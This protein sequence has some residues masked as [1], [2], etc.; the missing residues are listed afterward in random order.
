[1]ETKK[2]SP[3]VEEFVEFFKKQIERAYD[4]EQSIHQL[5]KEGR[6]FL[7]ERCP[8]KDEVC[9]R[10]R[11]LAYSLDQLN[12]GVINSTALNCMD[13]LLKEAEKLV[14]MLRLQC[15]EL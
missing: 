8:K 14:S 2:L 6:D 7:L 13:E 9:S 15:L 3:D 12:K 10:L 11:E 5:I 1:M 4:P